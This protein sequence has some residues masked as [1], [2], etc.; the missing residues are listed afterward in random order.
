MKDLA[1]AMLSGRAATLLCTAIAAPLAAQSTWTVNSAGGAQF[2]AIQPAIAAAGPG[3]R[4]EVLGAGP[5]DGFVVDRGVE[6]ESATG[7]I[8]GTIQVLGVPAGQRA[9][10]AGFVLDRADG[11]TGIV[12]A[13]AGQVILRTSR[14]PA[15]RSAGWRPA[16]K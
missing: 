13:C 15:T 8:C 5:Y 1:A 3:D 10:V 16:C 7:A 6:V 4:I 12:D 2:T 11:A 9:R 14:T